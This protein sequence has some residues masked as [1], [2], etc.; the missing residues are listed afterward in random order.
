MY[1]LV[2]SGFALALS[3]MDIGANGGTCDSGQGI[4]ITRL[5]DDAHGSQAHALVTETIDAY[6]QFASDRGADPRC[7]S[8][9][10]PG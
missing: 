6:R 8:A 1:M 3:C 9:I 5:L 10:S 7:R 2:R 4:L